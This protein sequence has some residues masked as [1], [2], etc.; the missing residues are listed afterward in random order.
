MLVVYNNLVAGSC[1]I[2][3]KV[4]FLTFSGGEEHVQYKIKYK[5]PVTIRCSILS[6]KDLMRLLLL[7]DSLR[8]QGI[9]SITLYIPYLPYARQDRVCSEGQ[10]FSL[11]V[12]ADILN[13]QRYTEVIS[14]DVHSDIAATLIDNFRNT[15]QKEMVKLVPKKYNHLISPDK[16]ASKKIG[17]VCDKLQ[18]YYYIQCDKIRDPA[19]GNITSITTDRDNLYGPCLI[20][21]DI[22]DGGRTFLETA[23][24]LKSKGAESVDLYV[25]HGI[26]KGVSEDFFYY[27]DNV[28]TTSSCLTE[29]NK[30]FYDKPNVNIIY[31]F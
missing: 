14:V 4:E 22:C 27:I 31:W 7:T 9:T 26:F 11:H 16:G 28:Y 12:F 1:A 18:Y 3:D 21:D 13:S 15:H 29:S 19:T 30:H 23:K 20:V 8:R 17:E 6:S 10:A 24:L 25:T 5:S 2:V